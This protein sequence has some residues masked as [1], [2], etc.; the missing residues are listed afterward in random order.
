[1]IN[2]RYHFEHKNII[3]DAAQIG[4]TYEVMMMTTNGKEIESTITETEAEAAQVYESTVRKYQAK[5]NKLTG[6]Y[7]KLRDDLI[8]ALQAGRAAEEADPEDGGTCNFDAAMIHLPRWI[9]KKVEQAAE[10][11]G[12]SCFDWHDGWMVFRPNTRS[13]GNA[14]SRNAEAMVRALAAMGYETMDYCQMD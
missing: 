11:A 3:I 1:M 10:E 14:R 5:A 8:K 6:R 12:S 13:Q 2:N 4:R 7:A 9:R